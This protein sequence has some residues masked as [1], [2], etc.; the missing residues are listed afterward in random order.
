MLS[1]KLN[2]S[3]D[4]ALQ[5]IC[6]LMASTLPNDNSIG[7]MYMDQ[8]ESLFLTPNGEKLTENLAR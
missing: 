7:L 4:E 3:R 5:N 8:D 6:I 1:S 2:V